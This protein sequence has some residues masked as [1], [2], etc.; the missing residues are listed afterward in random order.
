MIAKLACYLATRA[1]ISII[2]EE[3]LGSLT[4]NLK[5]VE[6]PDSLQDI[7]SERS[8][9]AGNASDCNRSEIEDYSL[10]I[11]KENPVL[12]ALR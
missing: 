4:R 8:Y 1:V 7:A 9:G 11:A 12:D 6:H 2:Q 3:V 5:L 10:A